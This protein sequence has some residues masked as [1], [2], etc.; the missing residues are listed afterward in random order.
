MAED[1]KIFGRT[2]SNVSGL[3]MRNT[4]GQQVVYTTGNSEGGGIAGSAIAPFSIWPE[5]VKNAEEFSAGKQYSAGNIVS[6]KDGDETKFYKCK[7]DNNENPAGNDNWE[8]IQSFRFKDGTLSIPT[9]G[10]ELDPP[11][12]IEGKEYQAGDYCTL[13]GNNG[14]GSIFYIVV[15]AKV[16]TTNLPYAE[17]YE[18]GNYIDYGNIT[19]DWEEVSG[20]NVTSTTLALSLDDKGNLKLGDAVYKPQYPVITESE[21]ES[22]Y[23]EGTYH[24]GDIICLD[25]RAEGMG[26]YCAKLVYTDGQL[27]GN[28]CVFWSEGEASASLSTFGDLKVK[29]IE[30]SD[31]IS[32]TKR[33]SIATLTYDKLNEIV[34]NTISST[35]DFPNNTTSLSL[36]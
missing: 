36:Y 7:T 14:N 3:K 12:Y 25:Y 23:T 31:S 5:E 28:N 19:N 35:P 2:Y 16:A 20:Y 10:I 34:N 6:L 11:E 26:W 24:T 22:I 18:Q 13:V 15:R 17:K 27:D 1:L 29:S 32:I 30:A 9:S 21:L 8:E 33:G 4:N